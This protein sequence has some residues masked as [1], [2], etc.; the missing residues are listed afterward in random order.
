MSQDGRYQRLVA[1]AEAWPLSSEAAYR[2]RTLHLGF[3]A[4]G[5]L[6]KGTQ[7]LAEALEEHLR[8]RAGGMSLETLRGLRD[9][10]WFRAGGDSRG[11]GAPVP[12]AGYARTLAERYLACDGH[13]LSL[14]YETRGG[15]S[16][17]PERVEH[18]RWLSLRLPPDLLI[19]ALH[20]GR[21][22]EPPASHVSLVTSHLRDILSAPVAE[23]HLHAGAAFS[24]SQ[25]WT[26]WMG[27]LP[28]EGPDLTR[29]RRGD[30]YP[31]GS[32]QGF[33][34]MLHAAAAARLLLAA[35]LQQREE[36]WG[37]PD[38]A[39]YCGQ[40]LHR[41]AQRTPWANGPTALYRECRQ[42]LR[43]LVTGSS[44][45]SLAIAR[46]LYRTLVGKA[47]ASHPP[48]HPHDIQAQDPLCRWLPARPGL[49]EPETRFSTRGLLYLLGPG[50]EDTTF[51]TVFWQYQRVRCQAYAFL[52]EEPGTAG[53]DW[54]QR[55]YRRLSALRGPLDARLYSSAL[56]LDGEGLNLRSLEVRTTPGSSWEEIQQEILQLARSG[57]E[58]GAGRERPL[59]SPPELGLIFHFI[60]ERENARGR[61]NRPQLHAN[62]AGS[63]T[64]HRFGAWYVDRCRQANAIAFALERTPEL[65]LLLRGVDMA[66]AELA[67]PTWVTLPL[68]SRLRAASEKAAAT[69]RLRR[70]RWQ[71][72][73][74]RVTCH[75]GEEFRRL[76]EGLRRIHEL[77]DFGALRSG[78]RIGHG[79]ALG[80]DVAR[81]VARVRRV[82][83]PAEERL[84]D[85]V[86][87]LDLYRSGV[88]SMGG[89][90]I[91]RV[92]GEALALSRAIHGRGGD[93]LDT[94]IE[95]RRLRHR[96]ELLARLGFP[97]RTSML[98]APH[99]A[100]R[101]LW[102]HLTD[103]DVFQ[104]GQR[105]IETWLDESDR[106]FLEA[107]QS[108]IRTLLREQEITIETNPSS[109]LLI[110]DMSRL[111]EHPML[112]LREALSVEAAAGQAP[113]ILSINSDD[114]ITFATR[115]ADEYAYTY[116]ALLRGGRTAS[117][118][119]RL[120]DTLRGNGWR[121]RFTLEAS[122]APDILQ[123]LERHCGR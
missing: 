50:R 76:D 104:R 41:L 49:A 53:L 101:L 105:P 90:R 37:S 115:L 58:Y 26:L 72:Q 29:L 100:V 102:R 16:D 78:D 107:A 52:T 10:A 60:K 28:E 108:W 71:V 2:Q 111:E 77:L 5:L 95:A 64:G 54:F 20:A 24:F 25:L 118:A 17:Q 55:H 119:L 66:S 48:S 59:Q 116:F 1:S 56:A 36:G 33:M 4:V 84:D 62:P 99:P 89:S 85:L 18:W 93:D 80:V 70:P 97:W 44:E 75:A 106:A 87:E 81:W 43:R 34:S 35:F 51:A 68:I 47:P 46:Q 79:L 45:Q 113:L 31:F 83:Q 82:V 11:S 114:P 12:L 14:R 19:A 94:L 69:L 121:S 22:D 120:M 3:S 21:G 122:A 91:E 27:W 117:E 63:S 6:D 13:Q 39:G 103:V 73:P 15:R 57:R 23:G 88:L 123:A 67:T 109:N 98:A 86:W 96:P 40:G 112:P 7:R 74:L 42:A 110:A 92:R 8:P 61:G 9:H 65:L 30:S 38:F 32:V